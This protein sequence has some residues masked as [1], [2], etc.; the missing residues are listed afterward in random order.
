MIVGGT[1]VAS[2]STSHAVALLSS[3]HPDP[4]QAHYCGGTLVAPR[5]VV[6]AAHCLTDKSV[7]DVQ[8]AGLV[9]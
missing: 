3:A 8:V 1:V 2:G 9:D 4:F 5:W 6:T 7:D